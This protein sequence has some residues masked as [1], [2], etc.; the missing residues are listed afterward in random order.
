MDEMDGLSEICQVFSIK[1]IIINHNQV[2]Y[3]YLAMLHT[4]TIRNLTAG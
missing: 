4:N 2:R 1:I 3:R